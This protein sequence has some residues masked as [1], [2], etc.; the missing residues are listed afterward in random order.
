MPALAGFNIGVELAQLSIV[1]LVFP[2]L[3]RTRAS[4]FYAARF[5]PATSIAVAVAGAVWLTQ[6]I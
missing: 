4:P 6:R 3:L 2:W 5:M 1:L